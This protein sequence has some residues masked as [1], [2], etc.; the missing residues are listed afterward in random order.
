MKSKINLREKFKKGLISI[1]FPF[2]IT[3]SLILLGDLVNSS[4]GYSI[5]YKIISSKNIKK[6][7]IKEVK[8][9][10]DSYE[11]FEP[12]R[13]IAHWYNPSLIRNV[14]F[15]DGSEVTLKYGALQNCSYTQRKILGPEIGDLC[16]IE[17]N[18]LKLVK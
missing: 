17:G 3:G 10:K 7:K 18:S 11:N 8:S 2:L 15:Q 1:T 5:G 4:K 6:E 13:A 9:Y 14:S 16:K 12:W